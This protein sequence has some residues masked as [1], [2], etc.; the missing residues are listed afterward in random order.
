[1]IKL[2]KKRIYLQHF[3]LASSNTG[4]YKP[5]QRDYNLIISINKL[6]IQRK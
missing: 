2:T 5:E 4:L 1:M 3:N 6:Q